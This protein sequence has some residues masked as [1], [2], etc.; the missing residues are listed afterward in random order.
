MSADGEKK[1][2]WRAIGV[3]IYYICGG[4]L[5]WFTTPFIRS[6][7]ESA[8]SPFMADLWL[9]AE[10]LLPLF[11]AVSVVFIVLSEIQYMSL[12]GQK[13]EH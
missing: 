5:I 4:I 11:L 3:L 2:Y 7:H 10:V 1:F 13:H 12:E 6:W 8:T 9:L